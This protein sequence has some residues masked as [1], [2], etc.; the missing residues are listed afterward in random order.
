MNIAINWNYWIV[1]NDFNSVESLLHNYYKKN[2]KI[3]YCEFTKPI[4]TYK[5]ME[6]KYGEHYTQ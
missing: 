2:Q 6:T 3:Y 4:I 5:D 1:D